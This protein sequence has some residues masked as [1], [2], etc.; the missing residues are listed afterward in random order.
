[1]VLLEYQ[2][3]KTFL[4]KS[5]PDLSKE[6]FAI[7]RVRKTVPRLVIIKAKNLLEQFTKKEWQKTTQKKFRFEKGIKRKSD[8]V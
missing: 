4:Q 8:K 3:I 1:M 6:V 7:K 2:N 5:V